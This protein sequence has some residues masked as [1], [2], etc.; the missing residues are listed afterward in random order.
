MANINLIRR[1]KPGSRYG[2][3]ISK[4]TSK[5]NKQPDDEPLI[6]MNI[7]VY[8][9]VHKRNGETYY[10]SDTT[11]DGSQIQWTR[12][13]EDAVQ[14]IKEDEATTIAQRIK[15]TGRKGI[16]VKEV[17]IPIDLDLGE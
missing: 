15:K 14:F 2:S 5:A 11:S 4:A 12:I 17:E 8:F 13:Q 9:V 1:K 10:M 16:S 6:D 3:A 7:D